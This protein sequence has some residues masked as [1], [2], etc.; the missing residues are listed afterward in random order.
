MVSLKEFITSPASYKTLVVGSGKSGFAALKFLDKLGCRV[1]LSEKAKESALDGK[2]LEWLKERDVYYETGGHRRETFLDADLIV[3]SPGVPLELAELAAARQA[4]VE[5]IGELGLGAAYLQIPIVAV[6]GTNGKTTVTK[7]IGEL[8]QGAGRKVFVGGNIGTPLMDYLLGEQDAE[9]AVLEVSSYQLDTAAQFRP[10]VAVLLNISPDH[11]D[12]YA[13]YDDYAAAKMRI[14]ACQQP[15]DLAVVNADDQEITARLAAAPIAAKTLW[16]GRELA[17]RPGTIIEDGKIALQGMFAHEGKYDLPEELLKSPNRENAMA[18]ILAVR[19]MACPDE[20][21]NRVLAEFQRPP[22]RLFRVTEIKGVS[23]F[24]D[25]KATNVGAVQSALEGM[26]QPVIL[27]AGGRDKGGDYLYMAE[28]VRAKVKKM[29]LIGEAREK[30]AKAFEG[31]TSIEKADSLE[32]AV[33]K[34][35]R[36]AEEGDAVLLSPACAS[37]DMFQSYADRGEKFQRAVW[38]LVKE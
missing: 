21:I 26:T 34:A 28:S 31:I 19:V 4:G 37:F 17:G 18:A 32:E 29:V 1:A 13:S 11:L 3:V 5:I 36:C 20:V 33:L 35:A 22:H 14:F 15:E 9:I 6:T 12:R 23:Y 27:I 7:L 8:L 24:D 30:M 2:L 25:S 16:F 10:D 38:N